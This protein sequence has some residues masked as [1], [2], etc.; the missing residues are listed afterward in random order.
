[1]GGHLGEFGFE[2]GDVGLDCPI[3]CVGIDRSERAAELQG[4]LLARGVLVDAISVRPLRGFGSVAAF[5][6]AFP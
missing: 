2:A 3:V 6:F 4:A 1:L 5:I